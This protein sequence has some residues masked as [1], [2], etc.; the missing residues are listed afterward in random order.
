MRK[1]VQILTPTLLVYRCCFACVCWYKTTMHLAVIGNTSNDCW[2]PSTS[3]CNSVRYLRSVLEHN[4]TC[5]S[6][7]LWASNTPFNGV[8]WNSF[9][10]V[11]IAASGELVWLWI[12][13]SGLPLGTRRENVTGTNDKLFSVHVRL[14][15]KPTS[16]IVK[17]TVG[18]LISR[19]L[20]SRD[21]ATRDHTA[22]V[23]IARLNNAAP[24]QRVGIR[25]LADF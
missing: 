12:D 19:D 18:A 1:S 8:T 21:L 2:T 5:T 15:T 3:T 13:D 4:T 14:S 16:N 11:D 17:H 7:W 23:D 9:T 10:A 22:R 20:T 24:D 6:N 25:A